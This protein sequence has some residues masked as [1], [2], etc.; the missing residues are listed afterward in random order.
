[1]G[2]PPVDVYKEGAAHPA[3][4]PQQGS[5]WGLFRQHILRNRWVWIV[6][7]ANFFVY[8]VRIGI[9]DW[10]PK[11]LV[12]AK[13]FSLKDAGVSLSAFELAGI[14][15]AYAAGWI[16]DKLLNGRRGPVSVVSMFLLVGC[17]LALFFAPHGQVLTMS[18]IFTTIGFLVYGPQMLIAVAAADFATKAAASSAVGLTGLFGYFGATL[19]GVGTGWLVDHYGWSGALWLYAG[20]A[21]IGALLLLATWSKRSPSETQS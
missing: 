13:G 2:L 20:S 11:Y 1:M 18:L 12:E 10:A 9:L 21:A 4:E 6:S 8:V 7:L 5:F 14:F 19:C 17:V 16:S 15:G 3:V